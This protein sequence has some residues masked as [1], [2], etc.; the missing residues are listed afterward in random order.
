M[1]HLGLKMYRPRLLHGLLQDDPDRRL[2]FCEVIVNDKR[3]GSGIVDKIMWSDEAHFKLS[4]A[5]NW[6]NSVY[7]STKNPHV[8]IGG[9]LN[10]PGI[11]VWAGLT[12]KG[13]DRLHLGSGPCDP[14]APRP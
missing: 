3:H 2:Q 11:T 9:Q 1:Q 8:T 5:V 10:Q 13:V 12:C 6:H 14:D 4:G 7:Y